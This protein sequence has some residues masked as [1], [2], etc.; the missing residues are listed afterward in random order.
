MNT[1]KLNIDKLKNYG[2]LYLSLPLFLFCILWLR[3]YIALPVSLI[4][5]YTI[6]RVLTRKNITGDNI[7]E[8]NIPTIT[9]IIFAV[10]FWCYTAGIGGGFYQ[11]WD[12][13]FKN[14]AFHDL[15]NFKWPVIYEKFNTGLVYYFGIWIVPALIGKLIIFLGFAKNTAWIFANI[16]L[17]IWC[18]SGLLITTLLLC[19]YCKCYKF[20]KVLML[21]VVFMAFSSPDIIGHFLVNGIYFTGNIEWWSVDFAL[22]SNTTSIFWA[23]NQAIPL[24]LA[25]SL[26]LEKGREKYI[27]SVLVLTLFYAPFCAIGLVPFYFYFILIYI[28]KKIL[29]NNKKEI[30]NY[31]INIENI[32]AYII[33]LPILYLFYTSNTSVGSGLRLIWQQFD[34]SFMST[35]FIEYVLF[36]S[37]EALTVFICFFIIDRHNVYIY[38]SCI[39]ISVLSMIIIG[40]GTEVSFRISATM[41]AVFFLSVVSIK[42]MSEFKKINYKAYILGILLL[43]GAITPLMEYARAA[44]AV[45]KNKS[46]TVVADS[47]KSYNSRFA[48]HNFAADNIDE[49]FFYKYLANY[50]K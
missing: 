17:Y 40:E 31:F 44:N 11:S 34:M 9:L 1:I 23:Y 39:S 35:V 3:L 38:I 36:I 42:Q 27:P 41:P 7:L 46:L 8:L 15:V 37:I 24:W 16:A 25:G 28:R 50:K 14:A 49:K 29:E 18:V 30:L 19:S 20:L 5:I 43:T 10:L 33:I 32:F 13:H 26:F 4:F 6:I 45:R 12:Q 2:I 22:R 48:D 21:L 47:I